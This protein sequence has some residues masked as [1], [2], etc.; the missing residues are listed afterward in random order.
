M[1]AEDTRVVV[2]EH[3][4]TKETDRR[5]RVTLGKEFA[6]RRVMAVARWR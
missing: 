2:P 4:T 1:A 3:I 6:D 5:G